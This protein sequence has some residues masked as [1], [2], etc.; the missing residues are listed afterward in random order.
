MIAYVSLRLFTSSY[1]F[2]VVEW[3]SLESGPF[4]PGF[5]EKKGGCA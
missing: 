5:Y 4:T 1:V 2:F 3:E